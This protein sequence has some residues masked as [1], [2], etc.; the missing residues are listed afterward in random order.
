MPESIYTNEWKNAA[1]IYEVNVRQYTE[2]GTF[3]AFAK[4][5]PRLKQMGVKIIW[6]MPITPISKE[7]RQG[8]LGSYYA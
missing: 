2:E 8:T 4:H 1:N 5:L 7:K 3:D 6:L